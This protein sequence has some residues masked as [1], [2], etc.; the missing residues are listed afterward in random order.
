MAGNLL[1]HM[2]HFHKEAAACCVEHGKACLARA[3]ACDARDAEEQ[4]AESRKIHG[5]RY[6]RDDAESW[7]HHA[8]TWTRMAD[9]HLTLCKEFSTRSP[10]DTGGVP[11]VDHNVETNVPAMGSDTIHAAATIPDNP[12]PVRKIQ[13]D[14]AHVIVPDGLRLIPRV[15]GPTIELEKD[16]EA[17]DKLAR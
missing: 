10:A 11:G 7:R 3:S 1:K 5:A 8:R 14:G 12:W 16:T 4:E 13:P 15:G 6:H 9:A 17:I 2:I